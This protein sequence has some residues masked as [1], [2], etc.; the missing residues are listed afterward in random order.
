MIVLFYSSLL[1]ATPLA[2]NAESTSSSGTG[3]TLTF[4][5]PQVRDKL[6]ERDENMEFQCKGGMFDCD[7]DRR[8]YAKE[9]YKNFVSRMDS[10]S[11]EGARQ[12]TIGSGSREQK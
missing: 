2:A 5:S 4:A 1:T 11:K 8:V 9:Q 10:G 6:R 7:G 12:S 3:I